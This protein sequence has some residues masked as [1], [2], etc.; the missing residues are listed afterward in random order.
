MRLRAT[1]LGLAE[2]NER[3]LDCELVTVHHWGA[4][5]FNEGKK[6]TAGTN[7]MYYMAPTGYLKKLQVLF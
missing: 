1:G 2:L 7:A 6:V 4:V 5:F 3:T